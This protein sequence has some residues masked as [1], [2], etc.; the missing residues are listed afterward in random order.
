MI[1]FG[2]G[3]ISRLVLSNVSVVDTVLL[4]IETG[5]FG[6]A[7]AAVRYRIVALWPLILLHAAEDV[8][9]LLNRARVPVLHEILMAVVLLA[10]GCWVLATAPDQATGEKKFQDESAS[11]R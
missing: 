6:F 8:V 9:L 11:G 4:M 5:V 7:Y 3:H 2:F 1:L 10:W